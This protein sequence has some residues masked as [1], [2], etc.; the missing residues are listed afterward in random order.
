MA[1][2][3]IQQAARAENPSKAAALHGYV[4]P[5][6]LLPIPPCNPTTLTPVGF[7]IQAESQNTNY[8]WVCLWSLCP[9]RLDGRIR[10]LLREAEEAEAAC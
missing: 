3:P 5:T 4:Y 7:V 1:T 9:A 6:Y 8:R 2:P 10:L